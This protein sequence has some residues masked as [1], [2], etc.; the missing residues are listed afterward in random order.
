MKD[1]F[2]W[3]GQSSG[4][5]TRRPKAQ[6]EISRQTEWFAGQETPDR[7]CWLRSLE[8]LRT[9]MTGHEHLGPT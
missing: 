3:D 8:V 6:N 9:E 1:G 7:G 5:R 2:T 4:G